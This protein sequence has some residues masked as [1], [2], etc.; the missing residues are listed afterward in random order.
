[1]EKRELGNSG[2]RV[3]PFAFGGNVF[4]WTV[5][6]KNGF[7]LLDVFSGAGFNLI[8]TA[9]VYST[10][11]PGNKGGESETML[12]EWM[13]SR[14]NRDSMVI[15]TKVG[16]PMGPDKKGLS[17]KYIREAVEASLKR[18]Q[19]SYIDLYQSHD[20]DSGVQM[21]ETLETYTD[22]IREGKVRA[23]GAS[24]FTAPRLSKALDISRANGYARYETFQP[25]YNL[26]DRS[27]EKDI[28]PLCVKE[29]IGIIPYSS[30]ASGFLT[31]KY[32]ST[33]D[34]HKSVR[35]EGIRKYLDEKGMKILKA[36]DT[37]SASYNYPPATLSLAWLM[38]RPAV[39]APIASAT[40][41][42]Q[43]KDLLKATE[44]QLDPEALR[45]LSLE[46][47]QPVV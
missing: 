25:A 26:Y 6:K 47:A 7:E 40:S 43:L 34:I 3:A 37:V 45:I 10:W 18:L 32:R 29:K 36:L 8:D 13:S 17:R 46:V 20:D 19:T 44:I 16:K 21:E 22:L 5:G 42:T 27:I 2:I 31:G 14:K 41:V 28:Q 4:G 35:G 33:Q 9:D 38:S 15:A 24:N 39:A 12:G 1:M 30:L 23:I 11:V